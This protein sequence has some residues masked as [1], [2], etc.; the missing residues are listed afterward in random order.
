MYFI[1]KNE[2]ISMY[3]YERVNEIGERRALWRIALI[4][5]RD[6]SWANGIP[7]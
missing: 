1:G 2:K 4:N 6:F 3:I 7:Y 5:L